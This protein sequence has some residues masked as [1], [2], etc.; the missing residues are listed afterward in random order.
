M[1]L[2]SNIKSPSFRVLLNIYDDGDETKL[3]LHNNK[4]F[5]VVIYYEIL[6]K[7]NNANYN[8]ETCHIL[9]KLV[10]TFLTVNFT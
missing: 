7:V 6:Q 3:L 10:S 2:N 5:I 9:I 4:V 8:L 1:N